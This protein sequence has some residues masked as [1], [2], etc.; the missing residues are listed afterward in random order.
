MRLLDKFKKKG[1]ESEN[2]KPENSEEI[3]VDR[4]LNFLLFEVLVLSI[5][6]NKNIITGISIIYI[7]SC[8]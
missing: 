3:I 1:F 8:F 7:L 2:V 6:L 4:F 5:K